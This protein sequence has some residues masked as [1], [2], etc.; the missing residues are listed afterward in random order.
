MLRITR[1]RRRRIGIGPF[2]QQERERARDVAKL[3]RRPP[4]SR[5]SSMREPST[6]GCSIN[7][8]SITAA[9]YRRYSCTPV[10]ADYRRR[11]IDR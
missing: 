3:S 4:R 2:V 6:R 7:A 1:Q 9:S 5:R 10:D 8:C 11:M